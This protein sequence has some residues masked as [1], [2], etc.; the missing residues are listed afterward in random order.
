MKARLLCLM[1]RIYDNSYV[2]C[3]SIMAII[4]L[5]LILFGCAGQQVKDESHQKASTYATIEIKNETSY[6][7]DVRVYRIV[8]GEDMLVY[9]TLML[10]KDTVE[11]VRLAKNT[12]YRV[13]IEKTFGN[14]F[15]KE[16]F[17]TFKKIEKDE[18]WQIR[19]K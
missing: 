9:E 18:T 5:S 8:N 13:C 11:E 6:P 2:I 1:R 14:T 10:T 17:C 3:M 15:D 4:F 19:R 12:I 16:V 7:Y